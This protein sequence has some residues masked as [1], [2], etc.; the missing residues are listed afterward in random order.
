VLKKLDDPI[1]LENKLEKFAPSIV[2]REVPT[3]KI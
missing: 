2:D 1:R 3:V